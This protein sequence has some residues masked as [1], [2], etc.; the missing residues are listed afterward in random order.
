[1]LEEG[2][3]AGEGGRVVQA[4]RLSKGGDAGVDGMNVAV[5]AGGR[6]LRLLCAEDFEQ[7]AQFGYGCFLVER[8]AHGAVLIEAQV[9]AAGVRGMLQGVL[10]ARAALYFKCV[11]EGAVLRL[12]EPVALFPERSGEDGGEELEA[13]GD[14]SEAVGSVVDG[15]HGGP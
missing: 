11:E 10:A 13:A 8:D 1:M 5:E 9:D 6:R 4:D 7:G 2:A 12:A 14:T 15:V 3:G